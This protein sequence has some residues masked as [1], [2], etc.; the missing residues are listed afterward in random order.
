MTKKSNK[1]NQSYNR[2]YIPIDFSKIKIEK[3]IPMPS[4]MQQKDEFLTFFT[5]MNIGESFESSVKNRNKCRYAATDFEK[6]NPEIKFRVR[7]M[8]DRKTFRMWKINN[9]EYTKKK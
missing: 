3:G 5:R 8:D 6:D 4:K 2:K 1:S 7:L 9:E